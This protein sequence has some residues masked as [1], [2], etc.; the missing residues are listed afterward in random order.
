MFSRVFWVKAGERAIWTFAIT[1]LT[2]VSVGDGLNAI[3]G[4]TLVSA[5]LVSAIAAGLSL[6]KS[7][8]ATNIGDRESPSTVPVRLMEWA[9]QGSSPPPMPEPPG[10]T[11]QSS[12]R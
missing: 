10:R 9:K 2:L 4:T 12:Q 3:P 11:E 5:L 1:L 6:V 8:A 7:I